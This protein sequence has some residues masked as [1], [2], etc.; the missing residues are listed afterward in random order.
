M[1]KKAIF[2]FFILSLGSI[3]F[4]AQNVNEADLITGTW[5]MPNNDGIIEIFKSG[6]VYNGTIIW[7]KE[8]EENGEPLKDK[9]NPV[10]SLKDKPLVGKQII[11][12]FKYKG[13]HTWSDG[14]FYVAKKGKTVE[15]DFILKDKDKLTLEI[16]F[17]FFSKSI[18]L[19]RL[20]SNDVKN[21]TGGKTD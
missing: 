6:D 9:N 17:L 16:S 21:L 15:P 2:S 4:F 18:E 13:N 8:R 19:T 14:T 3:A 20:D 1:L 5:A 11:K 7:L 10:D 12:D